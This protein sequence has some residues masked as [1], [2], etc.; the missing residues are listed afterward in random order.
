MADGGMVGFTY[1]AVVGILQLADDFWHEI[2][3]ACARQGFDPLTLPFH[4]FL[5]LVYSWV[6][7]RLKYSQEGREQLDEALFGEDARRPRGEPDNVAPE[8]VEEEMA[9]FRAA[10]QTLRSEIGRG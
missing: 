4:R 1:G 2:D 10:S 3:G 5:N 6:C 7:D 9:L 8:V